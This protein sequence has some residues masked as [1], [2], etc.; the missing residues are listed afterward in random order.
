MDRRLESEK[1]CLGNSAAVLHYSERSHAYTFCYPYS[2]IAFFGYLAES[3]TSVEMD[4]TLPK[5]HFLK[6][7][8]QGGLKFHPRAGWGGFTLL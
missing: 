3:R 5:F 1:N 6:L 7:Q 2:S 8:G 4:G